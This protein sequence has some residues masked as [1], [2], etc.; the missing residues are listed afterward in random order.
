VDR[1]GTVNRIGGADPPAI[2]TG[3]TARRLHCAWPIAILSAFLAISRVENP[4][5]ALA[6]SQAGEYHVKAAFL[7]HFV[8]LVEWPANSLG[9]ESS[10]VTLCIIGED[11]FGG[12]LEATLAGKTVGTRSLRVRHLKEAEELQ[13]CHVLFVSEH[14]AAHLA[15]LLQGLKDGPILTVGESNGFVEQGGM[16][17]FLVVD[18]KVRFEINLEAA[19]RAKLK[20]S[21]RLLLLAKTVIGNHG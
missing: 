6:Q 15:R 16:I 2:K 10:P 12:D 1:E 19:E 3:W 13:G 14:E 21:S 17:G 8:Q 4:G 18:N 20:I 5:I 11:P 9:G 7:Y